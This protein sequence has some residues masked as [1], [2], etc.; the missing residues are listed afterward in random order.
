LAL[1][2]RGHHSAQITLPVV[3]AQAKDLFAEQDHVATAG[4]APSRQKRTSRSGS[5]ASISGSMR[6]P[7]RISSQPLC[8]IAILSYG[9]VAATRIDQ[10]AVAQYG[11]MHLGVEAT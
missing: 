1:M 3:I 4:V 11:L 9:M 10:M 6:H 7:M 8:R 2:M 5:I